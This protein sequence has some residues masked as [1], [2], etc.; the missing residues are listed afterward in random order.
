MGKR[1]GRPKNWVEKLEILAMYD[2]KLFLLLLF[3]TKY[4]IVTFIYIFGLEKIQI[5]YYF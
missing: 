2:V 3:Q 5:M 4:K 1:K